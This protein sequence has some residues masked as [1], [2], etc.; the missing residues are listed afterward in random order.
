[1]RLEH[2]EAGRLQQGAIF[3][4]AIV[5]GYDDC[6]CFG[7]VLTA[8]CDLEHAKHTVVNYLPVVR[9][10]DWAR[11]NLCALLAK[12]LGVDLEKQITSALS[13]KGVSD[14]VRETF[15]LRE[16]ILKETAGIEQEAL[17]LKC[18]N[19]E[20][21]TKV[22]H[23]DEPHRDDAST[24][25]TL[26]GKNAE[27]L[28][29]DLIKQRLPEYYFLE[30]TDISGPDSGGAVV[31]LRRMTTLSCN[32]ADRISEGITEQDSHGMSGIEHVLTFNHDPLCIVTGV[33]RSP[34]LEHLAQQFA[35][36]FIRIGIKDQEQ[37]TLERHY[38]IVKTL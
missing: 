2:P 18:T 22:A 13:K 15:P 9:F 28:V 19:L 21:L 37:A 23:Y 11:K 38:A 34:D 33:L 24:I 5:P 29:E 30:A 3:N 25:I 32:I 8:R 35:H 1:M 14:K 17:L 12:R 16:V 4:C 6:P 31:L 20:V 26:A 7:L 27:K 36:L 10:S